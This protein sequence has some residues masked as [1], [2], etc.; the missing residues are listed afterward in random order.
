[1]SSGKTKTS[2]ASNIDSFSDAFFA[3]EKDLALYEWR[4]ELPNGMSLAPWPVVRF[5]LFRAY[6]QTAGLFDWTKGETKSQFKPAKQPGVS[7]SNYVLSLLGLRAEDKKTFFPTA[8]LKLA[9]RLLTAQNIILPFGRRGPNGEEKFTDFLVKELGNSAAILGNGLVDTARGYPGFQALRKAA[10]EKYGADQLSLLEESATKS[11]T[12]K[13]AQVISALKALLGI[14]IEAWA[15]FPFI[16][17]SEFLAEFTLW[18][19]LFK[20]S[21]AQRLFMP[22]SQLALIGAARVNGVKTIEIQHGLFNPYPMRFNWPGNP[23]IPYLPDEVWTWGEFWTKGFD[24]PQ[25]QTVKVM[26]K[27]QDLTAA[28]NKTYIRKTGQIAFISQ[29]AV[30]RDILDA[31]ILTAKTM[32]DRKAVFRNHPGHDNTEVQK[33]I[34]GLKLPNLSISPAEENILDLLGESE[35]VVG[36]FSTTLIEAVALGTPAVILKVSS[37]MRLQGLVD[38][39]DAILAPTIQDVPVSIQQTKIVSDPEYFYANPVPLKSLLN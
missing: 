37:W 27:N 5:E 31:A 39:G 8:N 34:S 11:D 7:G 20:K 22:I 24:L 9:K 1:M 21:N 13:Y 38:T 29:P 19:L 35:V 16:F 4:I 17:L 23:E 33:I 26:G 12:G 28:F 3:M 32:P 25:R 15:Q 14:E 2:K 30:W 36:A 10:I 18:D 6:S